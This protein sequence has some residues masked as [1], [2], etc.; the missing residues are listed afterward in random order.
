[1]V[2]RNRAGEVPAVIAEIGKLSRFPVAARRAFDVPTLGDKILL[3]A[4]RLRALPVQRARP[5]HRQKR[6]G[7]R[8][9][10][11]DAHAS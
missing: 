10:A 2:F 6:S 8:P 4:L 1:M 5:G 11:F 9:I 7:E 3:L